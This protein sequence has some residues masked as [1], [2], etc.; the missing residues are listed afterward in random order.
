VPPDDVDE[1]LGHFKP[2][3]MPDPPSVQG[4]CNRCG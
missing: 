2:F 3:E 4:M 1:L